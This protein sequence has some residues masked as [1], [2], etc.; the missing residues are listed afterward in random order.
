MRRSLAFL[1]LLAAPPAAASTFVQTSV[2]ETAR[3]SD[4]V[5][6]GR[7]LSATSRLTQD[8]RRVVTEVE[9]AVDRSWKGAAGSVVRV[10]VPGGRVGRIAQIVDAAAT[11]EQGEEVVVFLARRGTTWRV[12]GHA[13]GKYRVE[14]AEARP[15]LEHAQVL[16]RAMAAGERAVGPMSVAELERRVKEAR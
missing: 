7:V 16:P 5:V 3:S 15:G 12:M 2:E 4:A 10:I 6:H 13:L 11:F 14:G 9:I 8:G 1:L